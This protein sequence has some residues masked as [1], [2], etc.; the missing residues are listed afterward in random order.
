ML[1]RSYKVGH[2]ASHNATLS[3]QGLELMT[4]EDLTALIPVDRVVAT[5]KKW[6]MPARELFRNL[7]K[8]TSGR[9]VRA[10]VGWP[11]KEDA[12]FSAL[13]SDDEWKAWKAAQ[14]QAEADGIVKLAP[15]FVDWN[16]T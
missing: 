15:L 7:I 13:F 10:D 16:L 8:K 12:E 3:R 5:N 9:V 4:H 1:F 2:H 11:V 14:E 6:D